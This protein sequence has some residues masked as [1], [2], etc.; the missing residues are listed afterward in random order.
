MQIIPLTQGKVALVDD[1]DFER[2]NKHKW[3]A[4]EQNHTFY[5]ERNVR[6]GV[7]RTTIKMHREIFGLVDPM[8]Q[9]DHKDRN[10]LNNQKNN[11]R[12]CSNKDN[13]ANRGKTKRT[14]TSSIYKGVNFKKND[15]RWQAHIRVSKKKVYLGLFENEIAAALAYDRAAKH[16][17]GEFSLCN[18]N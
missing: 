9:V 11:L 7:K 13:Q 17:F 14:R 15:G 5:A 8:V 4:H 16:Y 1:E 6:T 12:A 2:L 10:G 18:F 3:F